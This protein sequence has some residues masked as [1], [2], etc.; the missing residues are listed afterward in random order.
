MD[1]TFHKGWHDFL[2][3]LWNDKQHSAGKKYY[4]NHN[5]DGQQTE[6]DCNNS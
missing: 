1:C 5:H 2:A 3:T 4:L 6:S